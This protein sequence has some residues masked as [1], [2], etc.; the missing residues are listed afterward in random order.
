VLVDEA[1]SGFGGSV[2]EPLFEAGD[3]PAPA[4]R[5]RSTSSSATSTKPSAPGRSA[6]GSA[7]L[8]VLKEMK[9]DATLP[10]GEKISV[11]GFHTVDE[12]RLRAFPD[13]TVLELWKNGV[14]MLIQMHL[15]SIVNIR[16][17]G[18][19]QGGPGRA[20]GSPETA[21]LRSTGN[22]ARDATMAMTGTLFERTLASAA[23]ESTFADAQIVA[24]M[25]E[26]EAA[27]AEAE[28]EEGLVPNAAAAAIAAACRGTPFDIEWIVNEARRAGAWR[29]RW[30]SSCATGSRRPRPRPRPSSTAAAPART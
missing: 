8:G 22:D 3:A 25:L 13:D 28:A 23:I 10:N 26:F 19:P 9:A 12:E 27:L 11:D 29:S 4:L 7:R 14:L 15:V 18:Q 17:L 30:C 5:R 21:A 24:A 20:R 16:H 2:G 6:S 1:W